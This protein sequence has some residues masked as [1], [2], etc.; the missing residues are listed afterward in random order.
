MFRLLML[1]SE[2]EPTAAA[3]AGE[4]KAMPPASTVAY[5]KFAVENEGLH[6]L[7]AQARRAARD[8]A[9]SAIQAL[10][11]QEPASRYNELSQAAQAWGPC[12]RP[13]ARRWTAQVV[14]C[15]DQYPVRDPARGPS[16]ES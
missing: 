7:G 2:H 13:S 11:G 4:A 3:A 14:I 9:M 15:P 8:T 1:R 12:A 5:V 10:S 6:E 16:V